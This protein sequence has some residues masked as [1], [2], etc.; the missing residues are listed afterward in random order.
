MVQPL[1]AMWPQRFA[2]PLKSLYNPSAARNAWTFSLTRLA[3]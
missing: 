2:Q 3:R 1:L